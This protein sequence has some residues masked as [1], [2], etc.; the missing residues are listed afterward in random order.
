MKNIIGF[1]I[2]WFGLVYFGNNF[3]A[4]AIA[5]LL[6][7]TLFFIQNP[8]ELALLLSVSIIGIG[9]DTL[10]QHLAVFIFNQSAFIPLWLMVLWPC[11]ATT[12]SHSLRF[13]GK[14][15]WFQYLAGLAAPLSYIAGHQLGVV[16][17]GYSITMTYCILAIIWCLL[18]MVFFQ[19]QSALFNNEA[20]DD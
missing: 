8:R 6:I 11:F 19:L 10:L 12:L 15:I 1:N 9:V 7:H 5:F 18:F 3:I 14:S 17:F 2:T 4:V 16:N 13:L 20:Y